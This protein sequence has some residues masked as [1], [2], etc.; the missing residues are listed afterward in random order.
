MID[1]Q[2]FESLI[3]LLDQERFIYADLAGVLEEEGKALVAM[4]GDLLGECVAAKETLLLR[5][6]ALDE[7]RRVIA[8]R[9]ARAYQLSPTE[10]TMSQLAERA[11]ASLGDRLLA[12]GSGLRAEVERCIE[13]NKKNE[14]AARSGQT[15]LQSAVEAVIEQSRPA[16]KVYQASS[17]GARGGYHGAAHHTGSA[18]PTLIRSQ[19]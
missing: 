2:Q 5:L 19:V 9:L 8:Q 4:R 16:D 3:E 17:R 13:L 14:R 12:A 6:R 1:L 15:I 18:K 10:I 11:P 7:S